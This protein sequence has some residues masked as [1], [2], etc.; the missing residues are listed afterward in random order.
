MVPSSFVPGLER[1]GIPILWGRCLAFG[2]LLLLAFQARSS[3]P[4]ELVGQVLIMVTPEGD[5]RAVVQELHRRGQ[6]G[7]R[8][9][10]V[11]LV[12]A[13][14]RV[15]SVAVDPALSN[16]KV[17]QVLRT[18]PQVQL[19]QSDH[20]LASRAIP[21]DP[22]FS[23][24]WHHMNSG[25]NGG[26]AD[27]DID[28]DLA[29]NITTGGS[30]LQGDQIVVC[31]V[32]GA[33]L[34][35]QDLVA[36]AWSNTGEVDGNGIDD[37]GNGY[38]DDVLGW[39]PGTNSDQGVHSGSHGTQ[40][41]GMIGARG[42]NGTGVAGVN[43]NVKIMPVALQGL[44]ES[45]VLAAYTYP[46]VMRRLYNS[47]N[48]A[49]GAFVVAVNSSW[50][51][52]QAFAEDHPLWC[53]FYDSL[54]VAGVLSCVAA[55]NMSAD[56]DVVGGMPSRCTSPYM[57]SV[58]AT[59]HADVRSFGGYGST[60]VDLAAPGAS[61]L[62]TFTGH[63]YG[64]TSGTSFAAPLVSG[65]VALLY[66]VPCAG[67]LSLAKADPAA[68]AR[69]VRDAI[70]ANVD[71]KPGLAAITTSGGRLNV[72]NAVRAVVNDC[73]AYMV[74][75]RLRAKVYLKGPY[76]VATGR[77]RDDLRGLGLIPAT[78]PYTALGHT[79]AGSGGGELVPASVLAV[80]GDDAVVDW[81]RVELRSPAAPAAVLASAHGLLQRDGDIVDV[82][83][84]SPLPL[85]APAGAYH[86]V[87]RHRNHLGC[88]TAA[89]VVFGPT[90]VQLDLSLVSVALYG[91]GAQ[92][93][94]A[95]G[96]RALWPGSVVDTGTPAATSIKYTG[97]G[98]DRDAVLSAVGGSL[99]TQ[100]VVGYLNA[101]VNLDGVVRYTGVDNDRDPIL[102]T[103]GGSIPTM[104]RS[105]QIP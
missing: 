104:L 69:A 41:A 100:T 37:D 96:R 79:N 11:R 63:G 23:G 25:G 19:A 3:S 61:V 77:M 45:A 32:E 102:I 40:V 12:S 85:K 17:L 94:V 6:L 43:W 34:L 56:L 70:L 73:D 35:H 7:A 28:S 15:W 2:A 1:F 4:S 48:G 31:V 50:G 49:R 74:P 53:A 21:N 36:N 47:T 88:M 90:A 62:T 22:Q 98:N 18:H 78:E 75:L 52:D 97:N 9:P 5:A 92:D 54:G 72:N 101:D 33:D 95:T 76:T 99:P 87:V 93:L 103:V 8:V 10:E 82:D 16:T 29:W 80:T 81:V 39:N 64:V 14:M 60:S 91:S 84:S 105:E 13:P 86:V 20:Q 30:T 42:N 38:V 44:S 89:P 59:N 57:I 66:A 83:G 68:G 58:T 51:L 27:A 67:L 24:Q 26:V 46:L 71:A 65:T 55:S